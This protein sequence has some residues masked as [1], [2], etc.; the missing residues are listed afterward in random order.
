M[1]YDIHELVKF[2]LPYFDYG[3]YVVGVD[4]AGRGPLA[5]PVVAAAVVIDKSVI[6]DE[7]NDSK[8]LSEKKRDELY[9]LILREAEDV[10]ISVVDEN[11]IDGINI[12][13]AAKRAMINAAQM[14]RIKPSIILVDGMKLPDVLFPNVKIIGGDAKSFRIAA[15]SIIAKVTR[16]RIMYRLSEKFPNYGWNHN[17][18]Y[19]TSEHIKAIERFGVTPYHRKSFKHCNE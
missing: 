2:D 14:L 12:Y 18:G 4:E 13:Q 16:D 5:G 6:I 8:K 17:K 3:K 10:T 9:P 19:P 15:A 11:I 7:V 1:T